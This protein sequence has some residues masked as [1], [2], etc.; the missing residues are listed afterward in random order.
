MTGKGHVLTLNITL[1][2]SRACYQSSDFRLST[3]MRDGRFKE[4]PVRA[5]KQVLASGAGWHASVCFSGVA[6]AERYG[7]ADV[8][9]WLANRVEALDASGAYADLVSTLGTAETWLVKIPSEHRRLTFAVAGFIGTQPIVTVVS[10]WQDV[11]GNEFA[12][13]RGLQVSET[14]PTRPKV[15]L[16]GSSCA[17]GK[18]DRKLML[19]A[20]RD[21]WALQKTIE[22]IARVNARASKDS[23]ARNTVSPECVV[24]SLRPNGR[25]ATRPFGFKTGKRYLP[26]SVAKMIDEYDLE[27]VAREYGMRGPLRL[28]GEVTA[29][30]WGTPE[31]DDDEAVD[32]R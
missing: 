15:V 4:M 2:S 10:N 21:R 24:T 17:V 22:L 9:Q 31:A 23:R 16:T 11:R 26:P 12:T 18:A 3:Q 32:F 13:D 6:Q 28:A 1:A 14:Q 7:M 19:T 8:D 25:T 30:G 29:A 27:A 5:H 20:V